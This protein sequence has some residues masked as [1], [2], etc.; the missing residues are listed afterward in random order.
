[1]NKKSAKTGRITSD[2]MNKTVV[3]AVDSFKTHPKYLK[4]YRST[5]KYKV[6]DEENKY[7]VGDVIEFVEC[8]PI[9]KDKKFKIISRS[10]QLAT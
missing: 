9:S 6:H 7:K 2:K 1:M 4:K 3:V 10:S 8:K 5:K